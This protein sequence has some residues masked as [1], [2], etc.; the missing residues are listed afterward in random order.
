MSPWCRDQFVGK[1][2]RSNA[3]QL[4]RRCVRECMAAKGYEEYQDMRRE[5]AEKIIRAMKKMDG[6]LNELGAVSHEIEDED[7][8]K[9]IRRE[10]A[11]LIHESHLRITVEV[12]RQF[13]DLHPDRE[14][15]EEI[16]RRK[17]TPDGD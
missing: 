8:R 7:E 15:I 5:V 14:H 10:I 6:V 11:N 12:A 3:P 2:Y 4:Y 13:P 1:G 16:R 17:A 9:K